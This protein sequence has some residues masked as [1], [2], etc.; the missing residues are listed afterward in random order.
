MMQG[1]CRD[2]HIPYINLRIQRTCNSRVNQ[3][4]CFEPVHQ[5][6]CTDSCIYLANPASY[7]Y[8]LLAAQYSFTEYHGCLLY[9]LMNIHGFLK[10]RNLFFHCSDDSNH[11][12][13]ILL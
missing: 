8:N 5:D 12:F 13:V 4:F 11:S 10:R 1:I 6:L 7:Y 3:H 2:Y 9:C